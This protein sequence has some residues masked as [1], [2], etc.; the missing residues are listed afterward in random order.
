MI[1]YFMNSQKIIKNINSSGATEYYLLNKFYE[2]YVLQ[3]EYYPYQFDG[4][5]DNKFYGLVDNKN[6]AIFPKD[7][8]L[9]LNSN[10]NNI[11]YLNMIF[12]I[13]AFRDMKNYHEQFLTG[14]KFANNSS[15]YVNLSIQK[16]C[17]VLDEAYTSYFNS[18][19]NIFLNTYL[20]DER[21]K[22]IKNFSSFIEFFI[23]FIKLIAKTSPITRSSFIKSIYCD[24][25]IN[26]LI[27]NF[28]TSALFSDTRKKA[29]IYTSDPNFNSFLET[30]KRFGF[31]V[32]RNAPWRM[33]ADLQSPVMRDYYNAYG[34]KTIDE[35]LNIGYHVA[36]YS[37]LD[38]LKTIITSVWNVFTLENPIYVNQ[39]QG[40]GCINLFAQ[41]SELSQ[42]SVET[43]DKTYNQ[44]W[45]IRLYMFIKY[46]ELD[47]KFNQ[48]IFD[49]FYYEATKLV[50]YSSIEICLD[51]INS[52]FESLSTRTKQK[53][54]SLTSK[55]EAV[56][57]L[58]EKQL[59]FQEGINF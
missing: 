25:A 53:I 13:D 35:L 50:D 48:K 6:R 26:G 34:F 36:Y 59:P 8:L 19:F 28:D 21:K 42:I 38:V 58:A 37:D 17:V 45:L 5:R 20:T 57:L 2:N 18:L 46:H 56:K 3:K 24:L 33:I 47:L 11:S 51:F 41:L 55:E 4:W 54:D 12:V 31:L 9:Y 44:N 40:T 30:A 1:G 7:S 15:F 16:G 14:N 29:D 43:F 52:K 22:L 32:D 39:K 23:S 49:N 27:I 10:P